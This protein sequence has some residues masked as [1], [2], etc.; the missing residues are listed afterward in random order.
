MSSESLREATAS[1]RL[2]LPEEYAMQ[3]SWREDFDKLTFILSLPSPRILSYQGSDSLSGG[4]AVVE[5]S[6]DAPHLLVGDINLFLSDDDEDDEEASEP[7]EVTRKGIIGEVELMIARIDYQGQGFGKIAIAIFIIYIL[8]QKQE[9]ISQ[10]KA[11][12]DQ[13][14]LKHLRVKIGKE[15]ERSLGLFQK[16]GF[17]KCTDTPNY[18]GEWELRL[19]IQNQEVVEESMR[20]VLRSSDVQWMEEVEYRR[21]APGNPAAAI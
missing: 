5:R 12:K 3:K 13:R 17:K 11:F 18:F 10:D 8:R 9:I 6:D 1:E 16:L 15:N 4:L 20:Q 19:E 14:Y 21:M 7:S 2:S